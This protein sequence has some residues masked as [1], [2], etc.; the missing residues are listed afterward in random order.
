MF[1]L[2][3]KWTLTLKNGRKRSLS[4][5]TKAS[6]PLSQRGEWI[7]GS[8]SLNERRLLY[9]SVFIPIEWQTLTLEIV[10]RE[11]FLMQP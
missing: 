6:I 5:E 3:D 4:Y 2:I 8:Q 1:N 7:P 10:E 11:V 9:E